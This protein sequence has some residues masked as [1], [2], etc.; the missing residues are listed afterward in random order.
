MAQKSQRGNREAQKP[1]QTQV[2]AVAS[3][4]PFAAT[5]TNPGKSVAAG[6]RK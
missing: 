3:T 6:K 5:N 1:K 2:K 4:S